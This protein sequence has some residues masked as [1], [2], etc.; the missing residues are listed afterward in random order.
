M[1]T[2]ILLVTWRAAYR[3]L[4]RPYL[5]L[6]DELAGRQSS[7]SILALRNAVRFALENGYAMSNEEFAPG[8]VSVAMPVWDD[9]G[10]IRAAANVALPAFRADAETLERVVPALAQT[11]R[12]I[13]L[14][15]GAS[16][17]WVDG[18]WR[19]RPEA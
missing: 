5:A 15:F 2:V 18:G 8:L 16:E 14:S 17:K 12:K 9:N 1:L 13:S 19:D 4:V 3:E 10:R 6:I 11:A 7:S